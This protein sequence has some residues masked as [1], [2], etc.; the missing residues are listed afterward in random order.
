MTRTLILAFPLYISDRQI[1]SIKVMGFHHSRNLRPF[2]NAYEL[3]YSQQVSF[4]KQLSIAKSKDFSE[5]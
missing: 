4:Q 5:F 3:L 2:Y 1:K